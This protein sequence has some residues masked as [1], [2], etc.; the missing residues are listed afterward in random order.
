MKT[1]AASPDFFSELTFFVVNPFFLGR[2][3]SSTVFFSYL[4]N[5]QKDIL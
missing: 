2:T 5:V 3:A 1:G 4:C